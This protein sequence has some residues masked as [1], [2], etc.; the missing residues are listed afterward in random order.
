MPAILEGLYLQAV[1]SKSSAGKF[2]S[3]TNT[4]TALA[5]IPEIFEKLQQ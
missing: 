5:L 3:C 1:A 4:T 2:G